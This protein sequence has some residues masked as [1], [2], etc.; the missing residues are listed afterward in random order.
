MSSPS[1]PLWDKKTTFHEL[2]HYYDARLSDEQLCSLHNWSRR[3]AGDEPK[4]IDATILSVE[5]DLLEIRLKEL[6]PV[7]DIF[8]VL[9]ADRTFHGKS[10][11]LILE[12]NIERF[13][14][15]KAKLKNFSY[16]GLTE[17]N[18]GDSP[19]K[20]EDRL[21]KAMNKIVAQLAEPGDLIL[22]SDVDEIPRQS[23]LAL[24]RKCTGFPPVLHLALKTYFYSFEFFYSFDDSWRAMVVVY[25]LGKF[26]Y[27]HAKMSEFILAD[28][29]EFC[30]MA[31]LHF[32]LIVLHSPRLALHLLLS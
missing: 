10:K 1:R 32:N 15:A 20:N 30:S 14:W 9:E 11:P 21:R 6:W 22:V 7:V 13:A 18:Y 5:L 23:T 24:F 4:V 12:Q 31:S 19:F 26:K 8:V 17:L 3:A 27:D 25:S 2:P 28:A 16:R 29:G